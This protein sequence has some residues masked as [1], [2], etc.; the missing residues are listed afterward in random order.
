[1]QQDILYNLEQARQW[2]CLLNKD[3]RAL[4]FYDAHIEIADNLKH[5]LDNQ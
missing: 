2:A 1:M 4:E 5:E 3:E